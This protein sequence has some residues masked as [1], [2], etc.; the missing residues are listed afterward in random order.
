MDRAQFER[1]RGENA[2]I[3]GTGLEI[4]RVNQSSLFLQNWSKFF[5][6]AFIALG[7]VMKGDRENAIFL[8]AAQTGLFSSQD[9]R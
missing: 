9:T 6:L 4:L 7:L 1:C 3:I 8:W 2:E 5:I